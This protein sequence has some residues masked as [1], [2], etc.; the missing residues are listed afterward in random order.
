MSAMMMAPTSSAMARGTTE[1]HG[2]S[3]EQRLC[4]Q[5]LRGALLLERL[6][7]GGCVG[8]LLLACVV[9]VGQV[10]TTWQAE[11]MTRE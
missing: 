1:N 8:D 7:V 9:T 6:E 11:V 5:H 4:P 10:P 3:E 2:R